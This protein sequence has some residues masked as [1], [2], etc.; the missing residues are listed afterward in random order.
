[1]IAVI[2]YGMGNIKSICNA[3]ELLHQEIVIAT[4]P[5]ALRKADAIV[6]PGVGAFAEGMNNLR[7]RGFLPIL[8]GEIIVKKK[9]YLGI[10]LGMQFLA[11]KSH[12]YGLHQGLGWLPGEVQRI[13]PVNPTF[14]IPHMGWNEVSITTEFPL[15]QGLGAKETF[16]FVHSYCFVPSPHQPS[17]IIA[18]CWHGT[19][20]S[21]AVQKGN[22]F[23]VQFH[24][25]K[26]QGAGIKL[27]Q[28][29]TDHVRS[30]AGGT[31]G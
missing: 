11:E 14:K 22:I 23:G 15:F 3:F 26:S 29:F 10:C 19:K 24:P 8:E 7:E 31:D 28:N 21:A 30:A 13:I 17:P 5:E 1:M 4:G 25:E 12:E 6:L 16:Y 2:D 18:T 20:I 27:L 9:P